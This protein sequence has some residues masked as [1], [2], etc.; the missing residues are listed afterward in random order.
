MS[1]VTVGHTLLGPGCASPHAPRAAAAWARPPSA[2]RLQTPAP[3]SIPP[4]C[5]YAEYAAH[6]VRAMHPGIMGHP[7]EPLCV[8]AG[9]A[10]MRELRCAALLRCSPAC[11]L[12]HQLPHRPTHPPC[13]PAPTPASRPSQTLLWRPPACPACGCPTSTPASATRCKTAWSAACSATRNWRRWCAGGAWGGSRLLL[14][15]LSWRLHMRPCRSATTPTHPPVCQPVPPTHP[16]DLCQHALPGA[17]G[18]RPASR[19]LPRRR[20]GRGQGPPDCGALAAPASLPAGLLGRVLLLLLLLLLPQACP[21]TPAASPC[22][23]LHTQPPQ[24]GAHQAALG[25]RRA[26]RAVGQRVVRCAAQPV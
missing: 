15:C 26:A 8:G 12:R 11:F 5:Q 17:P 13:T 6:Q 2:P 4:P 20:S 10:C 25:R 16:T 19:L 22:R 18:Q 1:P 21:T 7:G 24:A 3:P 14:L 9:G 23:P